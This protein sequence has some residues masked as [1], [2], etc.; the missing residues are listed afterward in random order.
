MPQTQLHTAEVPYLASSDARYALVQGLPNVLMLDSARPHS[1][2][3]AWDVMVADP[4]ETLSIRTSNSTTYTDIVN[5]Y[6]DIDQSCNTLLPAPPELP[7]AG[8]LAGTLDYELGLPLNHLDA[9]AGARGDVNLYGWALLSNH[10]KR[11]SVLV[12]QP[13][14]SADQRRDLLGRFKDT[15]PPVLPSVEPFQLKADFTSNLSRDQYA[16]AF[17]KV[18]AYI[19]A[20]DCYQVNLARCFT[21]PYSGNPWQAYA[22]LRALAAA[23]FA[24]FHD[25]GTR[26]ILSLSPER[27]LR[28]RDGNVQTRPIKGTRP[29]F[30]D[31]TADRQSAE[32]LLASDK[33]RAENVMIVDLL[34][35]DIG[36]NCAPGSIEVEA[37]FELE[38]YPAVHHLV[39]TV[40]GR[41][42]DGHSS[43]E[44]LRDSF[45]GGSI[46]GAPKRRAMQIISELEPDPRGPYCGSVFYR[47]PGGNM[48]SNIAIR[49]LVC[50]QGNMRC[51]GGGGLV[52]DSEME[53]EYQETWDK[54]GSFLDALEAM[55]PAQSMM[56]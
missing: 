31:V 12:M 26:Q 13:C 38:S 39:S 10:K 53:R 19:Q 32:S 51:W 47:E 9:V 18:L 42:A 40:V 27:F 23:P 5:W 16:A 35:N 56:P 24:A 37:L 54:V 45:P 11:A 33:D 8:G 6:R 41:L 34:R 15:S 28:V 44:L 1:A 25:C 30:E 49:T 2:R 22:R 50:E 20:G 4:I 17:H 52:A 29:R 46:T 55:P 21:A 43:L 48:D 14:L 3:G 36:R 7:F